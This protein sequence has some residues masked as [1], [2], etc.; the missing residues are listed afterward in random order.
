MNGQSPARLLSR[1]GTLGIMGT[2]VL[3]IGL[4]TASA[5]ESLRDMTQQEGFR[6]LMGRWTADSSEGEVQ[7]TL[8]WE[9]DGHMGTVDFKMGEYAYRGMVYYD[10]SQ[11]QVIEVGVDNR[12]GT[13]KAT[14]EPESDRMVK[15]STRLG[16]DGE[17]QRMAIV[18]SKAGAGTMKIAVHSIDANGT[19]SD[20]TQTLEM[21]R[22]PRQPRR[23]PTQ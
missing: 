4:S 10:R 15:K 13:A 16:A 8:R 11:D 1:F 2:V 19:L 5:Q 3:S 22:Q 6:W 14:W 9:L 23:Q 20:E 12:G 21:K 18:H 17:T 7:L